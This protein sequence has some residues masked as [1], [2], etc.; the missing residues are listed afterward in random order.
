[1]SRRIDT[2]QNRFQRILVYLAQK[3]FA[4]IEELSELCQI[5]TATIRRDLDEL[6]NKGKIL[7]VHGGVVFAGTD[8]Q[9]DP[10]VLA[11]SEEYTVEKQ[12]IGRAASILVKDNQTIYI[13]SGTTTECII[14]YIIERKGLT[15]ITRSLNIVSRL[16]QYD[17]INVIM[18]SGQLSRSEADLAGE[19]SDSSIEE[20]VSDEI[21]SGA[22]G[23]SPKTGLTTSDAMHVKTGRSII[24]HMGELIVLADHTKFLR[25]GIVQLAPADAISA[26]ITDSQTPQSI[27]DEFRAVGVKVLIG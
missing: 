7:R 12:A 22:Y 10:F 25:N 11:R 8:T 19:L 1:M 3:K 26:V 5:S 2:H 21:I 20:L 4:S 16:M 14:P 18:L 17:H 9:K 15:V 23:L 24:A 27:L 6:S 13:S